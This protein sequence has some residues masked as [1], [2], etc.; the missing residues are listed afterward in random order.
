M[1]NV[2]SRLGPA[3]FIDRVVPDIDQVNCLFAGKLEEHSIRV[4]Y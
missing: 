4:V 2:V 1:S 3:L